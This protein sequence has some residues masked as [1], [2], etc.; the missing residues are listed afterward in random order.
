MKRIG[1]LFFGLVLTAGACGS[2]TEDALLDSGA[3][4]R[5]VSGTVSG[6]LTNI[7]SV[8]GTEAIAGIET[9]ST[10]ASAKLKEGRMAA[11]DG[12][13][14]ELKLEA[15]K[16]YTVSFQ[17][18]AGDTVAVME[19]N[20]S[21]TRSDTTTVINLDAGANVDLGL[22]TFQAGTDSTAVTL[23]SSQNNPLEETDAD[24]DGLSDFEDEDDD[25]DGE[26]DDI[27]EDDDGDGK[28][29]DEEESD[30]D[31]DGVSDKDDDDSEDSDNDNDGEDDDTDTDDDNDGLEDDE[32]D[33][34]DGDG[35]S[36]ADEEDSE[37]DSDS[38][39]EADATDTTV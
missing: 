24:D 9:T 33:D 16:S 37:D 2:L 4:T 34:D 28:P 5:T 21:S 23:V 25:N 12:S 32:D 17:D 1:V 36:D 7:A 30:H 20:A 31:G 13:S 35:V 6:D 38:D 39:T 15:G 27:D 18:S 14:Y 22:T 10:F 29:D 26:D 3:E 19:W 8:V 11:A